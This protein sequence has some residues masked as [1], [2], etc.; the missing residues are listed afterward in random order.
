MKYLNEVVW[1]P[2]ESKWLGT[3]EQE[4]HPIVER[5][6]QT[7]YANII[8][9]GSAEGYY[10]VGLA[11]RVPS[12]RVYSYDVDPWARSQQRR[13]AHLNGVDNLEIGK[14]CTFEELT[15]RISGRTLLV[16]DIEGYEYDLLDPNKTPAL[17]KCDILVELHDHPDYGHT[18]QS[19]ADELVRRFLTSHEITKVGV[20]PRTASSVDASLRTKLTAQELADSMDERRSPNQLWLWLVL[21]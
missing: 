11:M 12:A 4:L 9:V 7:N 8:D 18:P 20:A 3:Y 19:G 5:I 10:A 2:I 1:G 21:R 17:G 15:K 14:Q 13:L 6:L 16:C